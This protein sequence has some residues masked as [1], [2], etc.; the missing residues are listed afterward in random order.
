VGKN[1][2]LAGVFTALAVSVPVYADIAVE[3]GRGAEH[4]FTIDFSGDVTP[5]Q[6]VVI[7][8]FGDPE[9]A[10]E[11]SAFVCY[12][13]ELRDLEN[14]KVRGIG[15]DCLQI[16]PTIS[17]VLTGALAGDEHATPGLPAGSA[18]SPQIDA[19]TFF[20]FPGG[21]L[22]ADGNTT[23]RP[24]F[25]GVGDG[26]DGGVGPFGAITHLTASI[27]GAASNIV[28]GSGRFRNLVGRGKVRLSGA[29]NTDMFFTA[30][31]GNPMAFSCIFNILNGGRG[32]SG[33]A[34]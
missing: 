11:L 6:Q 3:F 17:P 27:P 24:I 1:L 29:V 33:N 7:D 26:L 9:E 19:V 18:L 4:L 34:R 13:A 32:K 5:E 16:N 10:R 28:D 12:E 8:F 31:S 22:V 21:H 14:R 15:V 30:P 25:D 20:F 23:V 2:V